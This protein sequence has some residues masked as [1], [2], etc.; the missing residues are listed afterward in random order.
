MTRKTLL[1]ICL[2][3]ATL[4]LKAQ[5]YLNGDDPA[6]TR[7]YTLETPHYQLIYPIGVDS[8]ARTYARQLE[9]FR[10]PMGRSIGI[11]PGE[12]QRR[13]LPVVLHAY[14]PYSNGSVGWAPSRMDLYTLPDAYGP[15]PVPWSIQLTSHEPRHQA[16]FQSAG[17]G[18]FKLFNILGGEAWNPV[19][20]QVYF[21][22]ALGEGDAVVAETG[23]WNGGT[24]ARTADF[25]NYYRVALDQDEYR[26]WFRWRYGSYKHETPDHYAVGYLTVAGAR[27]LTG[28]PLIIRQ[29]QE[30]GR[31]KPWLLSGSFRDALRK[32]SQGKRFDERFRQI[33]DTVNVHW[34]ADADRRAPFLE[35]EQITPSAS[36]PM[37]YSTPQVCPDGTIFALREGHLQP[38]EMV[39]IRDGRIRHIIYI[40]S[41]RAPLYYE[42][43]KNRIYWTETRQD[44]RWKMSG[45]SVVSYYD[46]STGKARDLATGHYYYNAQPSDDG[47]LLV[48]AEYLP[49]G[50]NY[51]VLLS[52]EDGQPVRRTRVPDGIQAVEFGWLGETV[53]I[54]GIATEGYGIYRITPEG[55]W[56][57][58]L[59]PS[60]QKISNLAGNGNYLEWVSDRTGVNE[61]Y[62]YEPDSGRLLQMTNTR[63]GTTDPVSDGQYLYTV[64]QT[65][66]GAQLFRTPLSALQPREVAF[67]DVHSYF[68][69]DTLTAQERA[70]GPG[71]DLSSA[72]PMSTPKH[73][74]KL[75]HPLR[76][77]SWLP[78]YLNYD[79][80]KEGSMDLTYK[81]ASI[82]LSG[83]FQNT[84]GTVSGMVGYSLHRS[85]DNRENWRNA[86][87]AKVTYSGQYPVFEA[88]L[89]VGDRASRQYYVNQYIQPLI[90]NQ[91]LGV[92]LRKAPLVDLSF[93]AYVPL[94][95][96]RFGVT[97]GLIPQVRYSF[98]NNWLAT[99]PIQWEVPKRFIGLK[100]YYKLIDTGTNAN[101]PLQR[102][103]ASVRAY[104]VLSKASS[105]VYPRLGVGAELGVSVRPGL[106][107][108]F[109]ANLYAYAYGYLPG[110]WSTQG[111]KI[112]GMVQRQLRSGTPFFGEMAINTL[113]RGFQS[114]VSSVVAQGYPLQWKVTADYAIPIYVGDL[115]IPGVAYITHFVLTPHADFTGLGGDHLWSA[116]ADLTAQLAKLILPFDSSLGVSFSWLG[117]S[118]YKNTGQEKP[119]SVSLILG[120]DF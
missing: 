76:M 34:Q 26:N 89:D 68:L 61:L 84:L 56:E 113:P 13:K 23:L 25:L 58:V 71:P 112:T 12:G 28:N 22:W 57:E 40:N 81:T 47:N 67:T 31:K 65:L 98:S 110:I 27:Y 50:T 32:K 53:Y 1:A 72:V 106:S 94:T 85:P 3:L 83:F 120:M 73:Y 115:S 103:S 43:K 21:G 97:Y 38:A 101:V 35:M 55:A 96:R 91:T 15:D 99:D 92:F 11:T 6:R 75:T 117:G 87:H 46:L 82:G 52:T 24:R 90:T 77:H 95:V 86:F 66:E 62:R 100:T 33:L 114:D 51:V 70:L 78:L 54:Q 14:N 37:N 104:A 19:A 41:T 16:Q 18:W 105:N 20:W 5:F 8:L 119:W 69:A 107:H 59:A 39:A 42:P 30:T 44:A 48:T 111:L 79:A 17:K 118:W 29:T 36:F 64:S 108:L 10:V 4:P 80:V 88:S 74:N 93:R 45:S 109:P 102:L 49:E 9:Q 63:Y 116:G 2:L 7:W 60:V